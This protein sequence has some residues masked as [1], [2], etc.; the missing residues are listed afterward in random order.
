MNVKTTHE[1]STHQVIIV[2]NALKGLT[3][4]MELHAFI[5]LY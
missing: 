1:K 2:V 3:V 4:E 5:Y